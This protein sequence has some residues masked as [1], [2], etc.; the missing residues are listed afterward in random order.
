[1]IPAQTAARRLAA[2]MAKRPGWFPRDGIE[3][4]VRLADALHAH[5]DESN[6]WGH[7]RWTG[8]FAEMLDA[9]AAD[10]PALDALDAV[11]LGAGTRNPLAFPLLLYLAGARRVW[12]VEPE[13]AASD[14]DWRLRWGLQEMALRMLVG[15]IQ[16]RHFRRSP[17]MIDGFVDVRALF[18]G[19][20]AR[21][22]LRADA[23][24]ILDTYLEDAAIPAGSV[25]LV[26]S[27]SV[28]EH[29][30]ETERCFD[31][32]AAMVGPGGV[33]CHHID[34]SAHDGRDRFAFYYTTP[35][36]A[37]RR[38]DGLNGLRLSDYMAAFTARGF[39]CRVIDARIDEDYDLH[40]RPLS[41]RF[42]GY[43]ERDL[44]CA[45]AS[46]VCVKRATM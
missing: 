4:A 7:A 39:I 20:S 6:R 30:S 28:L 26:T 8:I 32:L 44:R 36:K 21:Q 46:L 9:A 19:T 14:E 16:S 18:F 29:V 15:D 38:S 13:L 37:A 5:D 23:V 3:L 10:L 27:R 17:A 35:K 34:L 2:A 43:S 11:C 31:A 45:R 40:R 33:M 42:A 12:V 22:A 24:R 41:A 25:G 1:M